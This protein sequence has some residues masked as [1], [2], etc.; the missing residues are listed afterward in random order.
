MIK[1]IGLDVVA[2]SRMEGN[3]GNAHFM[4]RVFTAAERELIGVGNLAAQRAA[5]NFA[6]KEALAKAMGCGLAGC[7]LDM[8]ETLRD[9]SG[10]P[11][12]QTYGKVLA[13][14]QALGSAKIWVSISHSAGVASAGVVLEGE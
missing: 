4:E 6:V 5:G 2:I 12:I 8:V 14:L 13:R 7:P 3:I 11:Y 9:P 1:G 10:A